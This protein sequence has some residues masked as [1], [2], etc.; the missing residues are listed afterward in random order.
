M[1]GNISLH[2]MD[3]SNKDRCWFFSRSVVARSTMSLMSVTLQLTYVGHLFLSVFPYSRCTFHKNI[4][5][6]S[7]S[8]P[9]A[10]CSFLAYFF[11][12]F[13]FFFVHL[14]SVWFLSH[15]L[16]LLQL[17]AFVGN[18]K[19]N[20]SIPQW[21]LP[22]DGKKFVLSPPLFIGSHERSNGYST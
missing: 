7:S 21:E 20:G 9:R 18:A 8:T 10:F 5:F 22:T 6:L 3:C 14:F 1:Q 17:F 16:Y 13:F 11:F 2:R 12:V 4:F 19:I 15:F